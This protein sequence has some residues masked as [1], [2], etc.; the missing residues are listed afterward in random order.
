L[1]IF[2]VKSYWLYYTLY[3]AHQ[4]PC[5]SS[6]TKTGRN[7]V[8]EILL[9]MALKHQKSINQSTMSLYS[10]ETINFR[11]VLL[12]FVPNDLIRLSETVVVVIVW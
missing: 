6:T 5:P 3:I 11:V 4:I 12:F 9:K 7:N 1:H 8:A 10:F 2:L